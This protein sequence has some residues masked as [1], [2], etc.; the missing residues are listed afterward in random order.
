MALESDGILEKACVCTREVQSEKVL[1][2]HLRTDRVLKDERT[3]TAEGLELHMTRPAYLSSLN[4]L[5]MYSIRN[6]GIRSN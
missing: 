6:A 3:S 5:M 4:Y 2:R 1:K